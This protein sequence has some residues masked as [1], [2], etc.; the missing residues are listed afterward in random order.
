MPSCAP[1]RGQRNRRKMSENVKSESSVKVVR[2]MLTVFMVLTVL[3]YHCLKHLL[4]YRPQANMALSQCRSTE[5]RP[6]RAET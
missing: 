5:R 3:M 2:P 6:K 4:S 1:L